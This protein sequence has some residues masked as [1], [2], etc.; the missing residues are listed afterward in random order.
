MIC[1]I[2]EEYCEPGYK[3]RI[4]NKMIPINNL[5]NYSWFKG[6]YGKGGCF[7]AS[8]QICFNGTFCATTDNYCF[9]GY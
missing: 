1:A 3:K 4:K 8:L 7:I 2:S 5:T 6:K 9:A